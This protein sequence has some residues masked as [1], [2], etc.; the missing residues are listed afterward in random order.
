[1]P[2]VSFIQSV[3]QFHRS[4]QHHNDGT[5]QSLNEDEL[6]RNEMWHFRSKSGF[7][8]TATGNC[9][10]IASTRQNT[11]PLV[12]PGVECVTSHLFHSPDFVK[13]NNTNINTERRCH[14]Y[15]SFSLCSNFVDLC[16]ITM[17]ARFR[18]WIMTN[19]FE[20]KCGTLGIRPGTSKEERTINIACLRNCDNKFAPRL[21]QLSATS[22]L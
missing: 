17:M 18:T 11:L 16:S 5:V 20:M 9:A 13:Q 15:H 10:E 21:H 14:A 12:F 19:C 8:A 1:M 2:S 4:A 22:S 3:Q 7:H 6:S